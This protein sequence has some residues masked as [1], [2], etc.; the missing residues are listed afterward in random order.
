ME[1]IVDFIYL[2]LSKFIVIPTFDS[3]KINFIINKRP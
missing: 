2:E 1:F 3:V